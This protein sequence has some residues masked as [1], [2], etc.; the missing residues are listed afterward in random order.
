MYLWVFPVA[1]AA[2][3]FSAAT[4]IGVLALVAA[5]R[6]LNLVLLGLTVEGA[7]NTM[8]LLTTLG[9]VG[10]I[11]SVGTERNR[12]TRKLL[13]AQSDRLA[14]A[15]RLAREQRS[16]NQRILDSLDVGIARVNAG[17]LIEIAN[18]AFRTIYALDAAT[19]FHPARVVEYCERRGQP[20]PA[21]ETSIA[22]AA[23]GELFKDE[24][25]W[26]FGL[27]G[28]W[29]ALSASTKVVDHGV[30][31]DGL[32]LLVEDVTQTVDP[33][34]GQEAV[35]RSI[36]H[37]L[38]N[39]LTAILGHIDLLLER[40]DLDE[41]ARKQLGVVEHAGERMQ[42]LIDQALATPD[43]LEDV[44]GPVDL[45]EIA[46]SSVD[47]FAPAADAAGVAIEAHLNDVL[48]AYADAFRLRQVVDNVVGNAIKYAQRGGRVTLRARRPS[49]D[50]VAL[51]VTDT[52]IGISDEDL[53]RI[54]D[55]EF[56]T[57]LAR[58]RGIPGTG[59]GLSISREIILSEGGR[60]DVN[61][62]L[63]QGTEVTI[64]LPATD[65]SPSERT[66]E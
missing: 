52:G 47:G 37:E 13:R 7:I 24:I 33:R 58:E 43:D 17:G 20:V 40:D 14:H 36:S 55:R 61:S 2:S 27:D 1:W 57:E 66:T 41:T 65:H 16:R 22:R 12:S 8:I 26:L 62:T 46:R 42:R 23:R 51:L 28:K 48:P 63:G 11:M 32:L 4:L 45:A 49:A 60:F 15:L 54:F 10:V 53:P 34:A 29:R 25:V 19:Q 44:R 9:F 3:Y 6:T 35:R 59:L 56:R 31:N 50:E 39:P 38:R 5:L 30:A 18:D 21:A 64:L